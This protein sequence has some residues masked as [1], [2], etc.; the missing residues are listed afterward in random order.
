MSFA[1]AARRADFEEILKSGNWPGVDLDKTVL[2]EDDVALARL[3]A[4]RVAVGRG[5]LVADDDLRAGAV[6]ELVAG[7]A[8]LLLMAHGDRRVGVG[9][10]P[11]HAVRVTVEAAYDC[12]LSIDGRIDV[13]LEVGSQVEVAAC[14]KPITFLQPRGALPFW[15]LLR[16][17]AELL[18]D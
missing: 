15:D 14:E 5:A 2:I 8:D 18:P 13:P 9:E 16:Q 3:V 1:T 6:G 12:L 7:D 11:Q 4:V 17:K 10:A